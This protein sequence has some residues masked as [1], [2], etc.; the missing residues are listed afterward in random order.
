MR[1]KVKAS[2]QTVDATAYKNVTMKDVASHAG[3][4]YSSVSV[5]LNGSRSSGIVSEATRQR[6]LD[7][8]E[9]LGY[10]RNGSARTVRTGRFGNVALLLSPKKSLSYLPPQLLSGLHDALSAVDMTLN[11]CLLPDEELAGPSGLPKILRERMCDGL[12]IDY[13]HH[14]PQAMVDSIQRHQVPA[15]WINTNQEFDCVYPRD[16]DAAV[17]ATKHLIELG[18]Q[19]IAYVHFSNS[20]GDPQRHYSVVD[21]YKGY[22]IAMQEAG[23]KPQFWSEDLIGAE[24]IN[25]CVEALSKPQRPTAVVGYATYALQGLSYAA[26]KL[27]IGVPDDLSVVSFGPDQQEFMCRP[28][29]VLIEPQYE[30]AQTATRMVLSKIEN[31]T[32]LLSPQVIEFGFQ[33]GQ[34][35][36]PIKVL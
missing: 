12:L 1:T 11:L 33:E 26:T 19:R 14:F 8:A 13:N 2:G 30:I 16:L 4:H 15:V 32:R 35:T 18:H 23:L 34:S 6:I 22:Q 24:Q 36:A 27:G 25:F 5:V 3:V 29:T 28:M 31:P 17:R 21:R 10:R 20:E 7:V 9:E